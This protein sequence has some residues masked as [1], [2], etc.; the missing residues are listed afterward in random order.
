MKATK[1]IVGA[2]CALVAAVALSAG[3]TFAW[4]S[5]NG[6]V[7]AT[8]LKVDVKTDNSYLVIAAAT[9]DLNQEG[10]DYTTLSLANVGVK[11]G[12]TTILKP[13]AHITE[14]GDELSKEG[15][16][17]DEN[18]PSILTLTAKDNDGAITTQGSWY[19]AQGKD[20]ADGSIKDGS[21]DYITTWDEYVVSTDFVIS[22]SSGS[23]AVKHIYATMTCTKN[24]TKKTDAPINVVFLYQY[25]AKD[26][27]NYGTVSATAYTMTDVVAT[28]GLGTLDLVPTNGEVS[29]YDHIAVKVMVYMDGNNSAVY[30][31]NQTNLTG[32]TLN[33]TFSDKAP[34]PN[35]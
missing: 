5:S 18:A 14:D 12:K 7:T 27:T 13:S 23:I 11:D 30:T 10:K 29:A 34:S 15:R 9:G 22:V 8:G 32:V 1:K 24:D 19:T 20:A 17:T 35:P 21:I 16:A 26:G 4:F 6:E 31:N 25:V 33:F 28:T 2:A 3:S